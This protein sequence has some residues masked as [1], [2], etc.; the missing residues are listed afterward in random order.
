[1]PHELIF[2]AAG[3][4]EAVRQR[5]KEEAYSKG[6]EPPH[7]D[8]LLARQLIWFMEDRR[9]ADKARIIELS[10]ELSKLKRAKVEE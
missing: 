2:D 7:S 8:I 1:M 6:Y 3:G 10:R 5:L 4:K 9:K